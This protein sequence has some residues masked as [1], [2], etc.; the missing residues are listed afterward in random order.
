MTLATL[1]V[2]EFEGTVQLKVV[3]GIAKAAI[4]VTVPQQTIVLIRQH[5]GDADL[6]IILEQVFILALHIKLLT[7][8]LTQSVE[9]LITG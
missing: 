2:I 7:L 8:V 3:V 6:G 9:S 5:K 4:A 1:L